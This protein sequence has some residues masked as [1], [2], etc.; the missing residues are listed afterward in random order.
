MKRIMY[1]AATLLI[2]LVLLS[3]VIAS[4]QYED[5]ITDSE[6]DLFYYKETDSGWS[7]VEGVERPDVDI[8]EVEVTE[9]GGEIVTSLEVKGTIQ[10][11]TQVWYSIS[12]EDGNGDSYEVMYTQGTGYLEYPNGGMSIEPSGFGTSTFEASFSSEDVGNPSSLSI[13]DAQT[14]DWIDTGEEGEHYVDVAG[15]EAEDPTNGDENG[16][17]GDSGDSGE[18]DEDLLEK[19]WAGSM[20]CIAISIIVPI[21][22]LVIIIVVVIKVLGSE[23]DEQEPPQQYQQPPPE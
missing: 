12:L 7:W 11:D 15:P 17:S 2:T 6:D 3:P 20:L 23:E 19:V 21:V 9:S 1:V 13:T 16:D 10:E 4:A 8:I 18:V 14:H 5:T 22:I